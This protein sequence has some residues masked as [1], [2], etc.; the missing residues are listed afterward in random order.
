MTVLSSL[1][2]IFNFFRKKCITVHIKKDFHQKLQIQHLSREGLGIYLLKGI[3][4]PQ[5][6]YLQYNKTVLK[7]AV[8]SSKY[9]HEIYRF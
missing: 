6:N 5:I 7:F 2:K 4:F 8:N 9:R 3:V 1:K